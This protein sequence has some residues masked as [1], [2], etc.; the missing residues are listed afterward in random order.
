MKKNNKGFIAISLIYSFFL[1]FLLTLLMIVR[2]YAHN[3][4]LLNDV[5]SDTQKYLNELVESITLHVENRSYTVGEE[6]KFGNEIWKVLYD[7]PTENILTLML[8]R[9]LTNEEVKVVPQALE[10]VNSSKVSMC[11]TSGPEFCYYQDNYNFDPYTWSTSVAK[12]IVDEWYENNVS[13]KKAENLGIIQNTYF[14]DTLSTVTFS[15]IRI[16]TQ[17]EF[18]TINNEDI[19]YLTLSL[20]ENGISKLKIGEN[21]VSAHDNYKYIRPIIGVKKATT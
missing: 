2:D 1:V 10:N 9:N 19:W 8:N 12:K 18:S 13:L 15:K 16:P 5:K 7:D 11:T 4:I 21:D 6:I 17:N 3:R 20:E 14:S